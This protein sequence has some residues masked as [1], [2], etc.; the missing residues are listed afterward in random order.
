MLALIP[1]RQVT[2][3]SMETG[4]DQSDMIGVVNGLRKCNM[5]RH[6]N[7]IGRGE[8]HRLRLCA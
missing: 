4:L 7:G 2:A 3:E 6:V 8:K 5:A 1:R